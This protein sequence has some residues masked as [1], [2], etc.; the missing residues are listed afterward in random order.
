MRSKGLHL[1]CVP[2]ASTGKVDPEAVRE[3]IRSGQEGTK[4]K[5]ILCSIMGANNE[6]GTLQPCVAIGKVLAEHSVAFHIDPEL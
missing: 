5:T 1:P 3:A 2:V 4:D 6:I